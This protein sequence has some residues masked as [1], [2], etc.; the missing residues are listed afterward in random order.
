MLITCD[1]PIAFSFP[2]DKKR[3]SIGMVRGKYSKFKVFMEFI[4]HV[5]ISEDASPDI[6]RT[7]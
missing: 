1:F 5:S 6:Q 3:Y 2:Q 7:N 4:S